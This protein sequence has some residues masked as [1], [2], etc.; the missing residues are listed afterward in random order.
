MKGSWVP[1]GGCALHHEC[2]SPC[3]MAR[4]WPNEPV[5]GREVPPLDMAASLY[6]IS[7]CE[8]SRGPFTVRNEPEDACQAHHATL[9]CLESNFC[10]FRVS[11]L[12]QA[13][14]RPVSSGNTNLPSRAN[15]AEGAVAHT[16]A[17]V[18]TPCD[19]YVCLV[20]LAVVSHGRNRT[21]FLHVQD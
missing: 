4:K 16:V 20:K 18:Q 7:S 5:R 12:V 6:W 19:V 15:L 14:T 3:W 2:F 11:S 10:I 21:G 13:S 9:A 8:L 1:A 17:C